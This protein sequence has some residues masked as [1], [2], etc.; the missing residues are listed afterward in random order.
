MRRSFAGVR[1]AAAGGREELQACSSLG[2]TRETEAE[3]RELSSAND[4]MLA[5]AGG[6]GDPMGQRP[7]A[8]LAALGRMTEV[9]RFRSG[10]HHLSI[11]VPL[12]AEK[13]GAGDW[14]LQDDGCRKMS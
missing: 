12:G 9:A 8:S 5:G 6:R 7:G 11:L 3:H 1:G 2:Q 4:A 14:G 10:L 13:D